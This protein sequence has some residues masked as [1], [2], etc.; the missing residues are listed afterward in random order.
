MNFSQ[1][2]DTIQILIAEDDDSFREMIQDFLKT[3]QRIIFSFK[4]GQE[5]I[6][7]L[8]KGKFDLVISDLMMPGADGMEVL[9]EAKE[10]NPD[11]VVIL[12]TG[13]ASLDSA[14]RAIRG[15]AYD[16]IR[17]PFKLDELEIVVKN[18][19]EKILLVRENKGLLR[20]LR[21]ALE[22]MNRR[23][24]SPGGMPAPV[25]EPLAPKGERKISEM[26]V[27]L[28]QLAPPN[29]EAL[30]QEPRETAIQDLEKLIQLRKE[31]F[32]DA[33]EFYSL[34]K[35]LLEPARD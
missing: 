34:K 12:V 15:G 8:R 14:L 24:R 21:E 27:F 2:S 17:K 31:G 28:N 29:Y 23:E 22:E 25:L 4:N 18:A 35:M 11:S 7:A 6:Q 19:C 13:Y 1:P 32:I 5:A 30:P 9:R 3:P 16:Y 33:L 10:R 26:D 20:R